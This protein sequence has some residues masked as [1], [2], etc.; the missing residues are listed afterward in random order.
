MAEM[1]SIG[2]SKNYVWKENLMKEVMASILENLTNSAKENDL[3]E[4]IRK[5]VSN[6]K[7]EIN[8]T[9][10]MIENTLNHIPLEILKKTK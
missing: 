10:D 6:R 3:K 8:E 5:Q 2:P 1:T 7:K 9:L 4:E